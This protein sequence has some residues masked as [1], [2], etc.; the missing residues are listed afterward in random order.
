MEGLPSGPLANNA[1]FTVHED[2]GNQSIDGVD[3][4]GGRDSTTFNPGVFGNDRELTIK[5]E[6]WYSSQL[7]V[8]LL[9]TRSDPRIGTQTFTVSGLS[10]SEPDIKLFELPEGFKVVDQRAIAPPAVD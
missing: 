10:L 6:Y 9:S 5:R 3:T 4:A 1:G 8:N 7:G 2:L